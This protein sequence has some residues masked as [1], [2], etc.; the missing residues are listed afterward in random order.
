MFLASL[1]T[2]F[3]F[4]YPV[5]PASYLSVYSRLGTSLYE[6]YYAVLHIFSQQPPEPPALAVLPAS[7]SWHTSIY[8]NYDSKQST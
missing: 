5:T 6:A 2:C 8:V 7:I 3:L 1:Y 4:Q